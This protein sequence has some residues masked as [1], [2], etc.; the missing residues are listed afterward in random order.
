MTEE[1][2]VRGKN[3]LSDLEFRGG[4]GGEEMLALPRMHH[5]QAPHPPAG[6]AARY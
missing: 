1:A 5:D 2:G 6:L 3:S 4:S